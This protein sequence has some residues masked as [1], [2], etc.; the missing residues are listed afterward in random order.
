MAPTGEGLLRPAP[1]YGPLRMAARLRGWLT[2][3]YAAVAMVFFFVISLPAMIFTGSGDL[4][5][6]LARRAWAPWG[7]RVAGC[8]LDSRQLAP[9]PDGPAIFASN[10]EST[11]DIWA[12]VATIPRGVRFVAKAELFRIPIFGWYMALGGHV[13]IERKD[14][15]RALASLDLAARKIRSGTS[16]IVYPE[17]TRSHDGRV[18]AFKKGPFV[19][20]ARAGVPVVPVAVVGAGKVTPKNLLHVHPGTITV[21]L[22][23]AVLPADF[24]ERDDLLREVRRRIIAMHRD[25]GGLGGDEAQAV[26]ARGQEGDEGAA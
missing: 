16:I 5:M 20:A 1:L 15:A 14:H 4:P 22:G 17:G 19:L 10:H 18:H 13:P 26:A 11:I 25:A 24:P 9:L 6:W 3:L 12:V 8:R 23:E 7:L 2:T 21:V